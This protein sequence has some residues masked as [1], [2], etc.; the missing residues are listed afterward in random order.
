[1]TAH[2]HKKLA[3]DLQKLTVD[4]IAQQAREFS[5]GEYLEYLFDGARATQA[6]RDKVLTDFA[7]YT[8]LSKSFVDG[9][10]LRVPLG[11]F[12]T[13]LLRSQHLMTSRLDSRLLCCT[14]P[15]HP[16]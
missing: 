11:P 13:E 3:P 7:R 16:Q 9:L 14:K 1:M 5:S 4:Q 15:N 10:D 12:S 2:F 6:Q 8:G